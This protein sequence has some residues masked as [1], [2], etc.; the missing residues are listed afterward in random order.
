MGQRI[1]KAIN[2]LQVKAAAMRDMK[3]IDVP[4]TSLD[5]VN[6]VA[7]IMRNTAQILHKRQDQQT[8]LI[9]ELNHRVKNTLA[10]IQAISRM[11]IRSSHDMAA[12]EEVFSARLLALSST[13][14]LLTEAAW[15]GVEF[16]ERAALVAE[17]PCR[18]SDE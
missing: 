2:V 6:T 16:S 11:T 10:T 7:A 9:Q 17:R 12:F 14:N 13:H 8:I 18:H 4:N 1:T 3:V 5:E 15:S